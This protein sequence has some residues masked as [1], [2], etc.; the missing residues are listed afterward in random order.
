MLLNKQ[1]VPN[2]KIIMLII[3][4][5]FFLILHKIVNN[6]KKKKKKISMKQIR[7]NLLIFLTIILG[8]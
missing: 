3:I 2:D 5:F 8:L 6:A 7:Y 1:D 4:V